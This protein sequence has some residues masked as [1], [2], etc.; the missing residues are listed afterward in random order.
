MI[1]WI[2]THCPAVLLPGEMSYRKLRSHPSIEERDSWFQL[3][4]SVFALL[5][6]VLWTDSW[7]RENR[8]L[9]LL[10]V[11]ACVCFWVCLCAD[12]CHGSRNHVIN[13]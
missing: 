6:T 2:Q 5:N 9:S 7:Y 11:H 8:I 13:D 4:L 3:P 1:N 12:F 10:I